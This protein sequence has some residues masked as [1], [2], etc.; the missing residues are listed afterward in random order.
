MLP[1]YPAKATDA[2]SNLE[3]Q[4]FGE[5]GNKLSEQYLPSRS[6]FFLDDM[7]FG[8]F[9]E[10]TFKLSPS[11]LQ[12]ADTWSPISFTQEFPDS[13][14]A[15]PEVHQKPNSWPQSMG[16]QGGFLCPV[17]SSMVE[18]T[19]LLSSPSPQ[20]SYMANSDRSSYES[21]LITWDTS[22]TL[23][24]ICGHYSD[25]H[26]ITQDRSIEPSRLGRSSQG[27]PNSTSE[28]IIT[29]E[30]PDQ[31]FLKATSVDLKAKSI[32]NRFSEEPTR[33]I[34]NGQG[35]Y[36]CTACERRFI[37]KGDW[38]RH[39]EG[40][41]PQMRWTCMLGEPAVISH[42]GW[43]CVFCN[44]FKQTRNE[45]VAH[46]MQEHKIQTCKRKAAEERT[47]TRKGKLKQH[48]QQVH[49]LSENSV[50]W[51]VW[52]EPV[53]KKFAWGCGYCGCSSYTWEGM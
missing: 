52:P 16:C 4:H 44:S 3:T 43:T 41:D 12:Q 50:L 25:N 34:P 5:T 7:N 1:R 47:F 23:P 11:V 15:V 53:K 30:D 26:E 28:D 21:S 9:S 48:L 29:E 14:P 18:V 40:H 2:S 46:L 45:M 33:H 8:D 27:A 32:S 24:S 49:S 36:Q 37:R 35:K 6:G 19:T 20:R 39:E 31:I 10:E 22:S 51:K 13:Y 17:S 38:K 42:T